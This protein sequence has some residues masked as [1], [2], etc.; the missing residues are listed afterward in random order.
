MIAALA[1]VTAELGPIEKLT[2]QER[3]KRGQGGGD[4]ERG[5]KYA[6]RG[7]DDVAQKAQPLLG[8]HGVAIVPRVGSHEVADV[9]VGG[10]PWTS[11]TVVV[12]W[13]IYGPGGIE[14]RIEATTIGEGRDNSD[15][16]VN[17]ATTSAY[18]NLLLKLFS[19]GDPSDDTDHE[20]PETS[21][22]GP[23]VDH[24]AEAVRVFESLRD[25]ANDE[26]VAAALKSLK[27]ANPGSDFKE[28]SLR[29]PAWRAEVERTVVQARSAAPA[30]SAVP[31]V[32]EV[33]EVDDIGEA[34]VE[35]DAGDNDAAQ[36]ELGEALGE[37]L[38]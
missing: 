35:T 2:S 17:K 4:D 5:V 12:H 38:S 19:I 24:A 26:R 8:K 30:S 34:M 22:R 10:K 14:D 25:L 16:G 29:D 32:D 36:F 23:Q 9:E 1:A 3:R 18:K 28:V 20:K 13:D 15:K 7:I 37:G 21:S 11:H 33:D 31:G 6:Y 27:A